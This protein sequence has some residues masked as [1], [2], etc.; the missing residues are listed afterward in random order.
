MG[1]TPMRMP[2]VT[3]G[4]SSLFCSHSL[5]TT[6]KSIFSLLYVGGPFHPPQGD[7]F[8]PPKGTVSSPLRGPF[9]P[10]QGDRFIPPTDT[11]SSPQGDRFGV[12]LLQA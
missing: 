3:S 2:A 10:P 7:R 12:V 8:I 9:H 6:G 4:A 5:P 1:D 11:V